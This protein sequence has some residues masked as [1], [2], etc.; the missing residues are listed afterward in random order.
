MYWSEKT[1]VSHSCK[2]LKEDCDLFICHSYFQNSSLPIASKQQ[3]ELYITTVACGGQRK[4]SGDLFPEFWA[5]IF[6]P[7][8]EGIRVDISP[9]AEEGCQKIFTH[10]GN[11]VLLYLSWVQNS[12][13]S[14]FSS[15]VCC[16]F[17]IE[18]KRFK[19]F[20]KTLIYFEVQIHSV[21]KYLY[22]VPCWHY[23]FQKG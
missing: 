6:K 7:C 11:P 8:P 21:V 20:W 22:S 16:Y 3:A 14:R 13:F 23:I 4:V 10:T 18:G 2:Q 12:S 1:M 15:E 17:W 9:F 5:W 19:K